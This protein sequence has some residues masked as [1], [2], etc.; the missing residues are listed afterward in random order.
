MHFRAKTLKAKLPLKPHFEAY[1]LKTPRGYLP[2]SDHILATT[3]DIAALN[4]LSLFTY[5]PLRTA[6]LSRLLRTNLS[7][8]S[9]FSLSTLPNILLTFASVTNVQRTTS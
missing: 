2:P 1:E 7:C 8:S 4:Y 9:Y 6:E 5:W 3:N